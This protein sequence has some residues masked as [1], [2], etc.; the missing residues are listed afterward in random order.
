MAQS[1]QRKERETIDYLVDLH[2]PVGSPLDGKRKNG[3]YPFPVEDAWRV[4]KEGNFINKQKEVFKDGVVDQMQYKQMKDDI[5]H[6]EDMKQ[7]LQ[8]NNASFT[9][10]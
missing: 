8:A 7:G 9:S 4:D 10:L 2:G 1:A 5:A 3:L 6:S